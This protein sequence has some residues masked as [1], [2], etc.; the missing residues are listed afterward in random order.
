MTDVREW[1]PYKWCVLAETVVFGILILVFF[2]RLTGATLKSFPEPSGRV[3]VA[4]LVFTAGLSLYGIIRRR[5]VRGVLYERAGQLGFGILLI[6]YAI[7]A[8]ILFGAPAFSFA[9]LILSRAVAAIL[10][11]VKI[12]VIRRRVVNSD[13]P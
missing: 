8:L 3:F 9:G 7:W 10:T 4:G 12:E 1:A 5:T 13:S 2:D 6:G 11:V